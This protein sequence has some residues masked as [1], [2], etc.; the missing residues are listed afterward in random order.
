MQATPAT[1]AMLLA[2]GWTPRAGMRLLSGGEA[3]PRPVADALMAAGAEVWNLYGPT[4]ITVWGTVA[5]V[6]AEGA[7]PLGEP[8]ANTTL[9]VLDPVGSPARLGVPGEL[10]IG[11]SGVTRGYLSRPG[12]TAERYVPDP[13]GAPGSRLYRTG[14]RVRRRT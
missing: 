12:L 14:D 13:F 1:W 6:A 9:Y 4:E 10:F 2:S 5:R 11:G 8:V 7:S 3:L